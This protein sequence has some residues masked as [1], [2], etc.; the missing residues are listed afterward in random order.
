MAI[1][2]TKPFKTNVLA[3]TIP[4][5]PGRDSTANGRITKKWEARPAQANTSSHRDANPGRSDANHQPSDLREK[6]VSAHVGE[7]ETANGLTSTATTAKEQQAKD[8]PKTSVTR[9]PSKLESM[10]TSP[11]AKA[12]A[13]SLKAVKTPTSPHKSEQKHP[14][15]PPERT[16]PQV[17]AKGSQKPMTSSAKT[18]AASSSQKPKLAPMQIS[19]AHDRGIGF[20]KPK[21]KSP[22]RPV[23]LPAS[24][25]AQTASSGSKVKDASRESLS[26]QSGSILSVQSLGRSPSRVSVSKTATNPT[27]KRQKSTINRPRPSLGPP[28]KKPAQDHPVTMREKDVDEGFLAR[29]MRPTQSSSFKTADKAPVTP[30]RNFAPVRR[31]S[32]KDGDGSAKRDSSVRDILRAKY[33]TSHP[34]VSHAPYSTERSTVQEAAAQ[35]IDIRSAEAHIGE[36]PQTRDAV[37][38]AAYVGKGPSLE[39]A[40][41][42]ESVTRKGE[43]LAQ[44]QSKPGRIDEQGANAISETHDV[45]CVAAVDGNT[46]EVEKVAPEESPTQEM[47]QIEESDFEV[48][49]INGKKADQQLEDL[50][51]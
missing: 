12:A 30:P 24:L 20:I 37:V 32:V 41:F 45:E 44:G 7:K 16:T 13:K 47:P 40:D 15:K 14:S 35:A 21:P 28:P 4:E 5:S 1:E 33:P 18:A 50:S 34:E 51:D 42:Q 6:E 11:A 38:S 27:L 2:E 49:D 25:M 26:R 8:Q 39:T 9:K 31:P 17:V 36:A 22:T 3:D 46:V 23:K 48:M 43:E 10:A 19:Q 29:M